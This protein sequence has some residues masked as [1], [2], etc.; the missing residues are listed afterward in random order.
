MSTA[1]AIAPSD[2]N[3]SSAARPSSQSPNSAASGAPATGSRP[4]QLGMAVSA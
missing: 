2:S 3:H 4:V 1:A